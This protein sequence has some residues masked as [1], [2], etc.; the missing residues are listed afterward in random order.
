M[1]A[2]PG[3]MYL[4]VLG[5]EILLPESNRKV[6]PQIVESSKNQRTASAKLVQD[7]IRIYTNYQ[8]THNELI[9]PEYDILLSLYDLNQNLNLIVY[10]RAGVATAA[11]VKM[12]PVQYSGKS[13]AGDWL[14]FGVSY[15]LEAI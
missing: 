15:L 6:I 11:T 4:G 9:G 10:D 8:I 13:T 2:N 3:D 12:H 1:M 14:Y 5:A 7:I